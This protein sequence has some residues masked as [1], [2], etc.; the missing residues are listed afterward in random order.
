MFFTLGLPAFTW[1][2]LVSTVLLWHGTFFIN[3]LAHVWGNRRYQ[4]TDTSRNNFFLAVLTL[5]EGWHNNHHTYM[6][7]TRQGFFWYEIDVTYYIIKAMS[8]V[9]LT[10]GLRK[11]PLELLEAKRIHKKAAHR[12][13]E[14]L[15]S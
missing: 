14:A 13:S 7:S 4:T 15:A 5:G 2:F 3:S 6:S 10:S 11:P 12:E 8:W 1:G 9:G